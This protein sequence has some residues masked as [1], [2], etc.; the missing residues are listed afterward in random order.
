MRENRFKLWSTPTGSAL[1]TSPY[2]HPASPPSRTRVARVRDGAGALVLVA[3]TV[4]RDPGLR[5]FYLRVAITQALA[6]LAIGLLVGWA[7]F[8]DDDAAHRRAKGE[9]GKGVVVAVDEARHGDQGIV[10]ES[11]KRTIVINPRGI[12]IRAHQGAQTAGVESAPPGEGAAAP[13]NAASERRVRATAPG[14]PAE[15]S[16]GAD[17]VDDE[18]DDDDDEG[19]E[20]SA[21]AARAG[22]PPRVIVRGTIDDDDEAETPPGKASPT[23]GRAERLLAFWGKVVRLYGA[24]V[25]VGWGVVALSRDYH[26]AIGRE[27]SLRLGLPPEDPP[28]APRV[29]LN[30]DWL[31]TK[32]KRRLR[33]FLLF[34]MGVPPLWAL[35]FFVVLPLASIDHVWNVFD[36]STVVSRLYGLLAAAWGAYWLTVF[37]GAKTAL[38]WADEASAGE[39]WFLRVWGTLTRRSPRAV[40]WLPRGYGQAWHSMSRRVFAPALCVERAPYEFGGLAA[41][42][43]LGSVPGLYPFVRPLVPVA[44]ALLIT[45][46]V[47]PP[48]APPSEPARGAWPPPGRSWPP[49]SRGG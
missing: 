27:A 48:P 26:D 10:I 9:H 45:R 4:W 1:L 41:L 6:T 47:P 43:L 40:A 3:Q 8:D 29:R 14:R 17:E 18:G 25:V 49:A 22:G 20:K 12:N 28:I 35:S 44:S 34:T 24:L 33:G 37:T 2:R 16:G 21:G 38:A 46:H 19:G 7:L 30:V 23:P 42:R 13:K 39:P 36:T 31:K 11:D 32:A 15:G 5:R